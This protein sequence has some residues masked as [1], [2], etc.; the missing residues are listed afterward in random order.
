MAE[1]LRL[2]A[3][4]VDR[5]S[6]PLQDLRAKLA[7]IKSP[8][9]VRGVG[10]DFDA[11]RGHMSRLAQ[12]IDQS[13]S[14]SLVGLGARLGGVAGA[15]YTVGRALSN[16][17]SEVPR[18]QSVS[19]ETGISLNNIRALA[20]VARQ[21][22]IDAAD[23]ERGV[24]TL[25]ENVTDMVRRR[26]NVWVELLKVAPNLAEQLRAAGVEK[27]MDK[28]LDIALDA[29][30]Q[31]RRE[32]GAVNAR[33]YSELIFGVDLSRFGEMSREELKAALA[34]AFEALKLSP[35]D[36]KRA[37]DLKRMFDELKDTFGGLGDTAASK[38][39]PALIGVGKA[40]QEAIDKGNLGKGIFVDLTTT[41]KEIEA[42]LRS[43]GK[44]LR[45][46]LDWKD[47]IPEDA[48]VR[49]LFRGEAAP[50]QRP[51]S[52]QLT[53][54]R[55]RLAQMDKWLKD[56]PGAETTPQGRAIVKNRAQL[57][58]EIRR[59]EKA[60]KDGAAEGAREGVEKGLQ[61]GAQRSGFQ[62]AALGGGDMPGGFGGGSIG[63]GGGNWGWA[64]APRGGGGGDAGGASGGVSPRDVGSV[65]GDPF[66]DLVAKAE[67]TP[68][69]RGYNET[70][71]YGR[72]TGGPVNLTG[73]TLDEVDALQ[74]RML[75]HPA[76]RWNSSA[77]GRYQIVRKTLRALRH[78]L[79]LPGDQLYDE[80]T[81][82]LLAQVLKR[83]RGAN[84]AGLRNEW[85]GLR[86]VPPDRIMQ[87]YRQ[88]QEYQAEQARR[89]A[90][91]LPEWNPGAAMQTAREAGAFGAGQTTAPSGTA[92]LD[93]TLNGF[94]SGWRARA[95]GGGLF[96]EV[97]VNRGRALV[98]ASEE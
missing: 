16:F 43:I 36:A 26:G 31:I 12:T 55:A 54:A 70:L 97:E 84:V 88:S 62:L 90:G 10:R 72:L 83:G 77:A 67:G 57:E 41:F 89:R 86:R 1:Q 79:G 66:L 15:L 21:V 45:N 39:A 50:D 17:T 76:N 56:N 33:R 38:L 4:V 60:I 3:T 6:K 80:P 64:P 23:V 37:Q 34:K 25:A 94:P 85:E 40:L 49:R 42:I 48:P 93:V 46:E 9:G 32:K 30:M 27:D 44:L 95:E 35:D 96:R 75:R 98:A 91:P 71:A 20:A 65:S 68:K 82:D 14:S 13:V 19:R 7:N 58:D 47:I 8:D 11:A 52:Q 92:K 73:M 53:D 28:A 5:F 29:I 61:G 2:E 59:L 18:L 51:S 74:T 63:R 69:G 24:K 78:K 81:Q 22:N 87:A